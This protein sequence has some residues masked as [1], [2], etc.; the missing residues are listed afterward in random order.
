MR[1]LTIFLLIALC[2]PADSLAQGSPADS[3]QK[4]PKQD[5]T[6][7]FEAL[8]FDGIREK[9]VE[10]YDKAISIF[11]KCK[12]LKSSEGIV[13]VELAKC[14]TARK[15]LSNAEK[16][17]KLALEHLPEKRHK[18][19][20]IEL[21]G[22]YKQQKKPLEALGI[23]RKLNEDPYYQLESVKINQ[24]LGRFDEALQELNE[25][26]KEHP[27]YA[28]FHKYRYEIYSEMERPDE[29]IAFYEGKTKSQP[30]NVWNY[31]KLIEFLMMDGK[32]D[33]ALQTADQLD[34]KRT[35]NAQTWLCL[36]KFYMEADK[37][38]KAT[39][40]VKKI[41]SDKFIDEKAKFKTLEEY[42]AYVG[43]HPELQSELLSMLNDALEMEKSA[44]SNLENARYYEDK[45]PQKGLKFYRSALEDQPN[46]F[47]LLKKVALMELEQDNLK[48]AAK[49]AQQARSLFPGQAV[50]YYVAGKA[51]LGSKEY[52]QA[53][54]DLK[55]ALSYLYDDKVLEKKIKQALAKA[56][57]ASGNEEKANELLKEVSNIPE[58]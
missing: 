41:L 21:Y 17:Y 51:K 32:A 39:S 4:S 11:N 35:G 47:K 36:S 23:A 26:E 7:K 18:F 29:A 37:K 44:A 5:E 42:R 58:Q 2:L 10:N 27:F 48:R 13:Y 15:D 3:I 9:A 55:E 22:L 57:Q 20:L 45:D 30:E 31:C 49:V 16:N 24:L 6:R 19:V 34:A 14:Y 50:F 54:T 46:N 53:I 33:K 28:E 52:Q 40:Y 38:E 12:D 1:T 43:E 56:Y 8:F 25:L